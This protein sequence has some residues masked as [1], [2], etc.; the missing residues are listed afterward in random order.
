MRAWESDGA[1]Q[2]PHRQLGIITSPLGAASPLRDT[3][4][5]SKHARQPTTPRPL[6]RLLYKPAAGT[7]PLCVT[8]TTQTNAADDTILPSRR[9]RRRATPRQIG[10]AAARRTHAAP[11]PQLETGDGARKWAFSTCVPV[12]LYFGVV[13]AEI[14]RSRHRSVSG[15][16]ADMQGEYCLRAYWRICRPFTSRYRQIS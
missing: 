5:L 2:E 1:A 7:P 9:R 4:V 11:A 12:F 15:T 10:P 8:M 3:I 14:P 13:M 6:C 16:A